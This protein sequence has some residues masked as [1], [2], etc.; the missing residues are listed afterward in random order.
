MKDTST[1]EAA[2]FGGR[3]TPRLRLI[4]WRPLS[5]NTMRGFVSVEMASGLVI[6]DAIVHA[7]KYGPWV[8]L[9]G[10][11]QLDQNGQPRRSPDGKLLYTSLLS[12]RSKPIADQFSRAVVSELLKVHPNAL[13]GG[14]A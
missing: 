8:A 13:D 12:W 3:P 4:D 2:G 5:K 10:K 11:P 7:G 14:E 1:A 6:H 9:P